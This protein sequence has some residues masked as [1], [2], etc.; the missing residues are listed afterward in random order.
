MNEIKKAII[1]VAGRG[2]RLKPL[3]DKNPKCLIEING[4]TI[5]IN[6]IDSLAENNL[7]EV[8]LVVGYLKDKIKKT[9]GDNWK[10]MQITYFDNDLF[11]KTNNSYSLWLGI[12]GLDENL[13]I[14][15]GG[16]SL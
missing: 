15:E 11:Q 3:T 4:K 9:I 8:I 6:T 14:L 7:K 12:E 16:P 13:L 10:G 2:Q 5:L 1:L